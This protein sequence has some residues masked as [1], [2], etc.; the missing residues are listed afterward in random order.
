[1]KKEF[2]YSYEEPASSTAEEEAYCY[3]LKR[4]RHGDYQPGDRLKAEDIAKSI[5][6]S[7]M[8]I[9]EAFRR[10]SAEGLL[11]MRPN[12]GA[13]VCVLNKSDIEEIFEIRAVLEGL[14]LRLA[15]PNFNLHV[16]SELERLL[17]RMDYAQQAGDIEWLTH[18][19]HFHEY[20]CS[21]CK[22]ERLM[23][24]IRSLHTALEPYLRV[25]FI[26]SENPIGKDVHREHME[27]LEAMKGGDP[28]FVEN[29]MQRHIQTTSAHLPFC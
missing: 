1:M 15:I 25:W 14:A 7:R 29:M 8:P 23:R 26:N 11:V 9:R 21:L 18:H 17:E 28:Y 6:M 2:Y 3:I 4:I 10:L 27:I 16:S 22:R 24:Q 13:S 12:R 20:L 5:D 19:R